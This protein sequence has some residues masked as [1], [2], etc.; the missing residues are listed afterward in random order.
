MPEKSKE[1]KQQEFYELLPEEQQSLKEQTHE[2]AI[3]ED[4]TRYLEKFAYDNL[5]DLRDKYSNDIPDTVVH[6]KLKYKV[7]NNWWTDVIS[8]LNLLLRHGNLP[9]DIANEANTFINIYSEN[10][11]FQSE[12]RDFQG[13]PKTK[14]D[15]KKDID[16]ADALIDKILE[17]QK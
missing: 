16:K 10:R 5:R 14:E 2:E 1:G 11:D 8:C 3:K 12:N 17:L 13:G 15:I 4:K 9:E 7:Q 6:G